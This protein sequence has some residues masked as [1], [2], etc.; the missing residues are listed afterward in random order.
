[1]CGFVGVFAPFGVI[2]K[3]E[4]NIRAGIEA[5]RYRGPDGDS[6]FE[7]PNRRFQIGFCRLSIIDVKNSTQPIFQKDNKQLIVGNG[8]IYNYIELK[9]RYNSYPYQTAGDIEAVLAALSVEGDNF[10]HKLSGMF[11][12]CIY[13]I[14]EHN[15]LLVRDHAGVKPLFWTKR[16]DGSIGFASEIKALFS[17]GIVT[18]KI[19]NHQVATYL[20]HG[21]V[22]SPDTIFENIKKLEAG[23]TLKISDYGGVKIKRYWTAKKIEKSSLQPQ[24][25]AE[26]LLE[27]LSHSV[28][29]QLRSDVP[30]G[31]LLSGGI[32][33]GILVALAAK[34]MDKPLKT[35]TVSFE[36][37]HYNEAPL[38]RL[39]AEMYGTNHEEVT[40]DLGAPDNFLPDVV[41][42]LGEPL[43]D[44]ALIPNYIVENCISKHVKVALNGCGGDELFAGYGRYSQLSVEKKYLWCPKSLRKKIIEPII[45]V[46]SPSIAWKLKRAEKFFL[47]GGGYLHDHSTQFPADLRSMIGNK[48]QSINAKQSQFFDE[49]SGDRETAALYADFNTYLTDDLLTLLDRT[50]MAFGVEGRVPFLDQEF[51]RMAFSVPADIRNMG[52]INK[53]LER[54]IA[55]N[56]LPSQIIN[57]PKQGFLSP[58]RAWMDGKFLNT[59]KTILTRPE[60]LARG[61]WTHSGILKLVRKPK[62][63]GFQIYTLLILELV[64]TIFVDLKCFNSPPGIS[65]KE[66]EKNL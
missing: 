52:F 30:I 62:L 40:V 56:L 46:F 19:E 42:H 15:L 66:L 7:S 39:V 28:F 36:G 43:N 8:E 10:V 64:A 59:V 29:Q 50:S 60:C 57:A 33:S 14:L 21:Y 44:A 16:S 48:E 55:Q 63:Y 23:H 11:S 61:W 32:D 27:K 53:G 22:P 37:A 41:W 26:G 6:F 25:I 34:H 58:M 1:M 3:S 54:T 20:S 49:F 17:A 9:E 2:D 12:L 35:L 31:A 4:I 5:I 51:V 38:A 65:L 47:D 18:P 24:E 13:N 45:G